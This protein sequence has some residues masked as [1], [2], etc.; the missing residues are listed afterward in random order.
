[1]GEAVGI[2]RT[3]ADTDAD[4]AAVSRLAEQALDDGSLTG[5]PRS[6]GA[7]D[8]ER[9]LERAFDGDLRYVDD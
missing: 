4:R 9:I 3:L 5:N 1:M 6:T 2:P 7:A 8:I